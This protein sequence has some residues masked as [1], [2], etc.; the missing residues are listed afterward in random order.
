MPGGPSTPSGGSSPKPRKLCIR[1][2]SLGGPSMSP[3]GPS[4]SSDDF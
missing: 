4:I 2:A 3:G 1:L